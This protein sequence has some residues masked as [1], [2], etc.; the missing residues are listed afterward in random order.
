MT[1]ILA[2]K[3]FGIFAL[4]SALI[5][6]SPTMRAQDDP[7]HLE[8]SAGANRIRIAVADFKPQSGDSGSLK[9]TF[10]TTLFA[11]LTA[12]GVFDIVSK[13]MIPQSTPGTPAEINLGQWSAAPSSAA[14]VAFGNLGVTNSRIVVNGFLDDAKNT[15][16]P[17]VFAKQYNEAASD[18]SARQIAHRFADE[19]ISRLGGVAGIAETKI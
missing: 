15:Q 18:D 6:I 8:T 13:D 10:D 19:I 17:Q 14:M 5:S 7:F 11:D 16:F 4:L 9:H 1:P 2:G 12:A 3:K